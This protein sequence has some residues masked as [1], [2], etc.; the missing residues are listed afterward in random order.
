MHDT[1][2]MLQANACS[3][4]HIYKCRMAVN[5]RV[6]T[7]L[8]L[9]LGFVCTGCGNSGAALA[10][11]DVVVLAPVPGSTVSVAYLTFHNRGTRPLTIHDV[12]ST[13]FGRIEMHESTV[14]DEV[15]RMRRLDSVM[16]TP[17]ESLQFAAG[18]KHLMLMEPVA[19]PVPGTSIT[20]L[21]TYNEDDILIL[22]APLETRD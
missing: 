15:A 8:T 1:G 18:G 11:T 4:T 9:M 13:E 22:N 10:V 12:S 5:S 7:V 21:I 20:L 2:V 3:Q 16:L 14:V 6:S 19:E 17:G